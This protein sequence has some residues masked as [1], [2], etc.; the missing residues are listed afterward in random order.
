MT[1]IGLR[2]LSGRD[3][4]G[5]VSVVLLRP[6]AAG[7]MPVLLARIELDLAPGGTP[8]R[9]YHAAVG[10][11]PAKAASLVARADRGA[12]EA[13][14][15]GLRAA[16]AQHGSDGPVA[17]ALVVDGPDVEPDD[18]LADDLAA[19]LASHTAIHVAEAALYRE[20][21]ET[22]A[23]EHVGEV[24]LV[25]ARRLTDDLTAAGVTRAE[26]DEVLAQWG[27]QVGPPWRKPHKEA[28][29]AAWLAL[30]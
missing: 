15:S 19:V 1:A 20:A 4:T 9:V 3:L 16:V 18:A 13:A 17:V 23:A 10:E 2:P 25:P 8:A 7:S 21:L 12:R 24:L 28:A 5:Q 11:S 6:D 22:A 14:S 30:V 29:L 26:V 27:R